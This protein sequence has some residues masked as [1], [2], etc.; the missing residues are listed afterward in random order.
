MDFSYSEADVAFRTELR[1]WLASNLP[2]GWGETVFEP[3]DEDERA[4]L[5]IEWEKKLFRGGW[6]GINL[7][8]QYGGRGA[9]LIEQA[10]YAEEMARAR[11][12]EG[13]NIIGRNLVGAALIHHGTEEQRQRFLPPILACE[14]I[15][16]Q[17]F[18]EP[19]AGSDLASVRCRAERDG[20]TFV[21]NGQK[22][23][24]SFAQYAHWCI[25]LARTDPSLPKHQGLS[26]IMVDM[27]SPGLR[28]QPLKQISGESEFNELFFTD[29]RVPVANV[30][31]GLNNGWRIA[32]TVLSAERGPD[33]AIGRQIRFKQ[34]LDQLLEVAREL[35]RNGRPAIEDPV[36]RDKL[37]RSLVDLELVRLNCMRSLS[38][39]V[40][41][42]PP[43][44]EA[45][46]IKLFW[47]HVAQQMYETA[48]E[49]LGPAAAIS[50]ADPLSA[51]RGRFQLSFLHS[52]AFTIYSGS[53][54]IQRQIIGERLLGLPK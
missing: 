6:A 49:T 29:V 41:G 7:P 31:G 9:T 11:A 30:L 5:R 36:L 35:D 4:Q 12:P 14:E 43:G 37:A 26:L 24:T 1:S 33:D 53:S 8:H 18:S 42:E 39:S 21:I 46:M 45:S 50:G 16:C 22:V 51:K 17:G 19:N 47:S 28:R 32:Q 2:A 48:L 54:E 15:W 23:W 40:N 34:E 52:R 44:A 27:H 13:I 20:D 3:D 25:L 10:I 38:K